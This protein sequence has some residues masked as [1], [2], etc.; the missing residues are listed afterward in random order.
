MRI[1][2]TGASGFIGT[3]LVPWLRSSGHEVLRLV[4]RQP[5]QPDELGWDPGA[6][7]VDVDRLAGVEA[8]V[9]LAGAGVGDHR[10]TPAYKDVILRSRVDGTMTIAKVV[11][12]LEPRPRV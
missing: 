7:S 12:R 11:G 8:V 5:R 4:R 9:H 10:W 6:G 1:A 2:V 3:A